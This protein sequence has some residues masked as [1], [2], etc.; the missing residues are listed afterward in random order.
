MTDE[1]V[2]KR[3]LE[4]ERLAR[5]EAERILELKSRELYESNQKLLQLNASLERQ[6]EDRTRKSLNSENQLRVLFENHPIPMLVYRLTDFQFIAVNQTA[7]NNY[8]YSREEFLNMRIADLHGNEE[9]AALGKHLDEVK[10]QVYKTKLWKHVTR[11]GRVMDVEISATTIEYGG[12]L[13]RL[14]LIND[15]TDRILIEQKRRENERKYRE[16]VEKV[17]DLIYRCDQAG[18]FTYMNPMAV[19]TCGYTADELVGTHFLRFVRKDYGKIVSQH[20]LEQLASQ[21]DSTYLE[22]PM[23]AKSGAEV[24]LGQTVNLHTVADGSVEII[25]H[26]RNITERKAIQEAIAQSEEKYRNIL[27]SMELGLLEVDRNDLIINAFPKFCELTG[28]EEAEL[29]GKK[30]QDVLIPPELYD[31]FDAEKERRTR[32]ETGVYEIKIRCK[33]GEEKWVIISGAPFYDTDG[34]IV[35]SLGVHLDISDRKYMEEELVKAK[36]IAENS[37][38]TKEVFMAN[39]SHEIRTPMNAIIGMSDL[40]Q[41]SHLTKKQSDYVDAVRTSANNLLIIINDI[42]DFSK[43]EAGKMGLELVEVDLSKLLSNVHSHPWH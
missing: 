34:N 16:L 14:V 38:R 11:N 28:Y 5:K 13:A 1:A 2:Y 31:V 18:N 35:G 15:V 32:G 7:I 17:S 33:N 25:A 43:I 21:T 30:A 8:G 19:K 10:K 42:L 9:Q 41:K 29:I 27:E 22:F 36:D 3:M 6:V 40:L 26:A 37:A 12:K 24:W 39:M 4:R 23:I 20:Y